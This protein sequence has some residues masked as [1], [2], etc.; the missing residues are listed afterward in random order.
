MPG[1]ASSIEYRVHIRA[2][3]D[4]PAGTAPA[5]RDIVK[6]LGL[7][8]PNRDLPNVVEP[9]SSTV[10]SWCYKL[11]TTASGKGGEAKCRSAN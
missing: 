3:W 11:R 6:F 9:E 5:V 10:Y 7:P 2:Q 1:K 4:T 8:E